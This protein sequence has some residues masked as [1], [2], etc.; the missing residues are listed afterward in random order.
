MLVLLGFTFPDHAKCQTQPLTSKPRSTLFRKA[1]KVVSDLFLSVDPE[2]LHPSNNHQICRKS[3]PTPL[4]KEN[5]QILPTSSNRSIYISNDQTFE[6][7]S[8]GLPTRRI[9]GWKLVQA[10]EEKWEEIGS[11]KLPK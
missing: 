5:L 8:L 10:W 4:T 1:L 11:E 7:I 2:E 3:S 9:A 6:R